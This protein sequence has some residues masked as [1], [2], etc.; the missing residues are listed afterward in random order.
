MEGH[1]QKKGRFRWQKRYFVLRGHYMTYFKTEQDAG[2][3]KQQP[4]ASVD[5]YA[6]DAADDKFPEAK[7]GFEFLLQS[8][9]GGF[10]TYQL[11]AD[12][13]EERDQWVGAIRAHAEHG[14]TA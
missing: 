1:L 9:E 8:I 6:L 10:G 4:Q 12:T 7:D 13:E 14:G 2:N 3:D 5:L 11:K